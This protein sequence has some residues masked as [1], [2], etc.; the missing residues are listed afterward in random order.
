[1][2]N[3]KKVGSVLVVGAGIAGMQAALDCANSGFK[4]Y[5]LE[6][7]PA[8]GDNMAR[9][10]KTFPTNDCSMCMLSPKLVEVAG[11][12]NIE[13]IAYADLKK[14]EGEAGN[15]TVTVNKRSRFIDEEKC[16]GCG[17]C[18]QVCPVL[19]KD[20]FNGGLADRHAIYR[21][22]PQAIPNVYTIDKTDA[23]SP[24]VGTCP[25]GVNAHGYV[26]LIAKGKFLEALDVVRERMPFAGACGRVCHHPCE[27][28]CN[29][30]QIDSAVDIRNLKRFVADYEWDLIQNG[31]SIE[32][33]PSAVA[34]PE[35][36]SYNETIAIV[37]SGPSGL[38][39]ANDLAIRGYPVTLFESADTL[40][41]MLRKGIPAYR[42]PREVLDYE[43]DLILKR[44]VQAITGQSL[45]KDFSIEDLKKQ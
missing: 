38:T 34:E 26:A 21:P 18:E 30:V 16:T 25:A 14:V 13:I 33:E 8:I 39:C 35:K 1:M 32:R 5:L 11:H 42:L 3:G 27:S 7:D 41:G 6:Q 43:I 44:G 10:D 4:V 24:C 22:Y 40:G 37:G 19:I 20:T 28:S 45:G 36:T 2:D 31:E 9:L 17:D 29:R 15:F 12:L 23:P